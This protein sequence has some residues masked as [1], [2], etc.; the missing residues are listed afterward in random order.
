MASTGVG[1]FGIAFDR[2]WGPASVGLGGHSLDQMMKQFK[3]KRSV[4]KMKVQ[5]MA[6]NSVQVSSKSELS[7][8]TFDHVKFCERITSEKV[9]AGSYVRSHFVVL[10]CGNPLYSFSHHV[11]VDISC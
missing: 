10:M 6:I 7:L 4:A 1:G 5:V 2:G 8:G 3:K 9:S 11:L